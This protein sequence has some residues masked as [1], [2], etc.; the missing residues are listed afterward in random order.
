M[1]LALALGVLLLALTTPVTAHAAPP[2]VTA[3]QN[4]VVI[5]STRS[6]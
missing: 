4:P 2:E 1:G 6:R 3:S 5:P